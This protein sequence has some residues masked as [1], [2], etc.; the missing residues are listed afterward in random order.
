MDRTGPGSPTWE[1]LGNRK[2]LRWTVYRVS[3]TMSSAS[4]GCSEEAGQALS[5][6]SSRAK[7]W[8]GERENTGW[9]GLRCHFP[10]V[11]GWGIVLTVS[12]SSV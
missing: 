3:V 2:G 4:G 6:A 11:L 10:E 8:G 12:L 9:G 7:G 5:M 1:G